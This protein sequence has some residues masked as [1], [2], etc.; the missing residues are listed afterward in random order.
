MGNYNFPQYSCCFRQQVGF[1]LSMPSLPCLCR[2]MPHSDFWCKMTM[3][4]C[5]DSVT[6]G[7]HSLWVQGSLGRN[8]DGFFSYWV[9]WRL[10]CCLFDRLIFSELILASFQ[11]KLKSEAGCWRLLSWGI[12]C[13]KLKLRRET[14]PLQR[15]QSLSCIQPGCLCLAPSYV[16]GRG[17][18][19]GRAHLHLAWWLSWRPRAPERREALEVSLGFSRDKRRFPKLWAFLPLFPCTKSSIHQINSLKLEDSWTPAD[20]GKPHL[21]HPL[22]CAGSQQLCPQGH[23]HLHLPPHLLIAKFWNQSTW[24]QILAPCSRKVIWMKEFAPLSLS[25][26]PVNLWNRG[27]FSNAPKFRE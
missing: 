24:I 8:V 10:V 25:F 19:A 18:P 7:F 15:P 21:C 17:L 14:R 26:L 11:T 2:R 27:Y 13:G 12:F 23:P 20:P 9:K 22:Q 3:E 6:V 1:S 4:N 5:P 16:P